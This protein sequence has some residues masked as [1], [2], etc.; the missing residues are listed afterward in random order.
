MYDINACY[1]KPSELYTSAVKTY[2]FL[3]SMCSSSIEHTDYT[4]TV[5]TKKNDSDTK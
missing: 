3:R 5:N 1:N 2:T 4:Y